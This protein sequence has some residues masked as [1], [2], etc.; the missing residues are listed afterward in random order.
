M[1]GQGK[2]R[3]EEREERRGELRRNDYICAKV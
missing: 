1:R 3:V 2:K